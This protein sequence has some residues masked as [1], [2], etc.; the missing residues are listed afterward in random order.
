MSTDSTVEQLKIMCA[1]HMDLPFIFISGAEI[2]L[3]CSTELAG[4]VA[5]KCLRNQLT[6]LE[7][8]L[9]LLLS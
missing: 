7:A 3:F 5:G 2:H 4:F 9:E 6:L 8:L 1:V